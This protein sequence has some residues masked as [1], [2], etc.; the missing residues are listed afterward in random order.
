MIIEELHLGITRNCSLYCEHCLRGEKECVNIGL[1]T[2]DNLFKD[3]S[4]VK[5]LLITGGEPLI[6][7]QQLER[8]VQIIRDRG[9][10]VGIIRMVTN[11]TI[12]SARVLRV[13]RDL[14]ELAELDIK[15][16]ANIFHILELERL[17]FLEKRDKNF[18]ILRDCLGAQWYG[19][20]NA[21]AR[22][23]EKQLLTFKGRTKTLTK[24]R[25]AEINEMV[26]MK[27][28]TTED[29]GGIP[30]GKGRRL[31]IV[32]D[33]ILGQLTVDAYGNIVSYG[34]EFV[35]EDEEAQK[36]GFNINKFGLMGALKGYI[37]VQD[38]KIEERQRAYHNKY[39]I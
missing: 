2:L 7:I 10:K 15:V 1:E 36:Y 14:S 29:F 16:S 33:T 30:I 8:L 22:A 19:E 25:L 4:G 34:L 28:I 18:E 17:G 24:E 21:E 32:D 31:E 3:I 38:R 20:E 37:E 39:G 13:L 6:A 12:M 11:G 5:T 23:N 26:A 35:E 27:Y 9:I